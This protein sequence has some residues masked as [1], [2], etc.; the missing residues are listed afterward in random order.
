MSRFERD[1]LANGVRVLTAPMPEAQSSAC[2][3][4]F[5]TGSRYETRDTRGTAHFVEHMLFK[6]T[7][8]RPTGRDLAA[9]VDAIGGEI[10]AFTG[11]VHGLLRQ[12][13]A[14]T[15]RRGARPPR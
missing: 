4:G 14:T 12:V 7:E 2:F 10:N 13:R 5:A 11:K 6:G 9:E 1:V 15:P 8:H 3:L